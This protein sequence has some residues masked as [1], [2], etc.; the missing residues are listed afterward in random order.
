MR[1]H[2]RSAPGATRDIHP[3]RHLA[4]CEQQVRRAHALVTAGSGAT[5]DPTPLLRTTARPTRAP[6]RVL[7]HCRHPRLAPIPRHDTSA[8][9]TRNRRPGRGPPS[10]RRTGSDA[11][12]A[13]PPGCRRVGPTASTRL[14]RALERPARHRTGRRHRSISAAPGDL[15]GS[16]ETSRK[17]HNSGRPVPRPLGTRSLDRVPNRHEASRKNA[18]RASDHAPSG[19]RPRRRR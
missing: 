10:R 17:L 2:P 8:T 7:D 19:S 16:L 18:V 3:D 4:R 1:F 5:P 11:R 6:D 13:I 15:H 14:T 12:E 9:S